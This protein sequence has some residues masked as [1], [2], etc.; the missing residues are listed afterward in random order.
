[1]ALAGLGVICS[2]IGTFFVRTTETTNQKSLLGALRRGTYVSSALVVIVSFFLVR[3]TLGMDHIGVYF[4]ILCGLLAGVLI[5][6]FTEYYTSD[7]YKPTQNL[8][9]KSVTGSAT[10]IIG[11]LGLGMMSTAIPVIIVGAAVLGSYY[12]AGGAA[13]AAMG[14]YGCLLYTSRR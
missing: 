6:Y 13:D 14:L 8:A 9:G 5:G 12:L 11:G 10:I 1:M 7:S 2:I 4:A 3:F